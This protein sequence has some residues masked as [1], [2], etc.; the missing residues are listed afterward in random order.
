MLSENKT[1]GEVLGIKSEVIVDYF[2]VFIP[3]R[4]QLDIFP[5]GFR[6]VSL[7]AD[8]I[9]QVELRFTV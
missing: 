8:R 7:K 5:L 6:E 4:L 3:K 2:K 1:V 9:P